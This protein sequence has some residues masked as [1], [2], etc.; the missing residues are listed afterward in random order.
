MNSAS[1][2][3]KMNEKLSKI[4]PD[5]NLN[6]ITNDRDV[7]DYLKILPE[8]YR[9][10]LEM[11]FD[12][13]PRPQR[14]VGHATGLSQERI[15]HIENQLLEELRRY[16]KR[17]GRAIGNGIKPDINLPQSSTEKMNEKLSKISPDMNLSSITNDRDVRDFLK[18]LSER[19]RNIL[20]MRFEAP[21]VE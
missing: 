14:E 9:N 10:I 12:Y 11:R 8:R 3:E 5:L 20:E 18:T 2:T 15:S 7:Q 17:Q 4:S 13:P 1:P 16:L 19:D 6:S 21:T